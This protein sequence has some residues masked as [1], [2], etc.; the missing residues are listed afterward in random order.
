MYS[1]TMNLDCSH[2]SIFPVVAGEQQPCC[3][4]EG[5]KALREGATRG[6]VAGALGLE[7][8]L[9]NAEGNPHVYSDIEFLKDIPY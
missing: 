4:E 5:R 3:H 8:R 9:E 2:S 7:E 6:H 1:E